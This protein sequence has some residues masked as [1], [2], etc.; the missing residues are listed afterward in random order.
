LGSANADNLL[1]DLP[2]QII[3]AAVIVDAAEMQR[4]DDAA[5]DDVAGVRDRNV[6]EFERVAVLPRHVDQSPAEQQRRETAALNGVINIGTHSCPE[7]EFGDQR[8]MLTRAYPWVFPLG[9]VSSFSTGTGTLSDKVLRHLLLQHTCAAAHDTD[10]I[11]MIADQKRRHAVCRAASV[12]VINGHM[13]AFADETAAPD[14]IRMVRDAQDGDTDAQDML[15]NRMRPHVAIA[16]AQIPNGPTE[17]AK[18]V[19]NIHALTYELGLP[20][21]YLTVS[22]DYIHTAAAVLTHHKVMFLELVINSHKGERETV[23]ALRERVCVFWPTERSLGPPEW[24]LADCIYTK[25][26]DFT[27]FCTPKGRCFRW[28]CMPFGLQGEPM[29]FRK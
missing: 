11:F 9:A 15:R 10:V 21:M 16:A 26:Q 8:A 6:D 19:A 27:A 23:S 20:S 7:N 18:A 12:S 22:P 4:L 29:V 25:A 2:A 28:N 13:Q 5:C 14:F 17:R 24:F 3:E 1:R